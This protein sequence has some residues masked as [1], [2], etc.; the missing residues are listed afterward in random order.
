M[1]LRKCGVAALRRA[2]PAVGRTGVR[3]ISQRMRDEENLAD[4]R[5]RLVMLGDDGDDA[6]P[7]KNSDGKSL[8]VQQ[9]L[10]ARDS[11]PDASSIMIGSD[12]D[13]LLEKT[14]DLINMLVTRA[15]TKKL[16]LDDKWVS[17]LIMRL[18]TTVKR[19][20]IAVT[21]V[22]MTVQTVKT[23]MN[24]DVPFEVGTGTLN[25]LIIIMYQER[26]DVRSIY[27]A[28]ALFKKENIRPNH[29]TLAYMF[30]VSL[31]GHRMK[32]AENFFLACEKLLQKKDF[33]WGAKAE[34]IAALCIGIYD[35]ANGTFLVQLLRMIKDVC[36]AE[37]MAPGQLPDSPAER[38]SQH[39]YLSTY[40]AEQ[41]FWAAKARS[42]DIVELL[43]D[44]MSFLEGRQSLITYKLRIRQM[45][46][47]SFNAH[48]GL[49]FDVF[50]AIKQMMVG[51]YGTKIGSVDNRSLKSACITLLETSARARSPALLERSRL[52]MEKM[53]E[54]K[55][56]NDSNDKIDLYVMQIRLH[57]LSNDY[58]KV[59]ELYTA[60]K[61]QCTDSRIMIG[62]CSGPYAKD[63]LAIL[64]PIF[65]DFKDLAHRKR[66][67]IDDA[68]NKYLGVL[69]DCGELGEVIQTMDKMGDGKI[70]LKIIHQVLTACARDKDANSYGTFFKYSDGGQD[71][72]PLYFS[73]LKNN[74]TTKKNCEVAQGIFDRM[75][76]HQ[77]APTVQTY[78]LL[79][80]VYSAAKDYEEVSRLYSILKEDDKLSMDQ[81]SFFFLAKAWAESG[82]VDKVENVFNEL[83]ENAK[84]SSKDNADS[85]AKGK[86]TGKKPATVFTADLCAAGIRALANTGMKI[87]TVAYM[88]KFNPGEEEMDWMENQASQIH[89]TKQPRPV[90]VDMGFKFFSTLKELGIKP[91]PSVYNALLGLCTRAGDYRRAEEVYELL[92][93]DDPEQILSRSD[94]VTNLMKMHY[95]RDRMDDA[96]ELLTQTTQHDRVKIDTT[97]YHNC[98]ATCASKGSIANAKHVLTLMFEDANVKV[99]DTAVSLAVLAC[100]HYQPEADDEVDIV[101]K[102]KDLL[103][104]Y[105]ELHK[106]HRV[107]IPV[108]NSQQVFHQLLH[109][110]AVAKNA[111]EA[112]NV[113][114]EMV[115][116]N[117]TVDKLTM[118]YIARSLRHT[119]EIPGFLQQMDRDKSAP[120][121]NILYALLTCCQKNKDANAALELMTQ[122]PTLC[123]EKLNLLY[124]RI[125]ESAGLSDEERKHHN[126]RFQDVVGKSFEDIRQLADRRAREKMEESAVIERESALPTASDTH[127]SDLFDDDDD[128]GGDAQGL[129]FSL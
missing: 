1:L 109:V 112:R 56:V 2:V 43:N 96:M 23:F 83:L 50:D 71:A 104:E 118:S 27:D 54:L 4:S 80:A 128:A 126:Q 9:I 69:A 13:P 111:E 15:K 68:V 14:S 5:D 45:K 57:A 11:M 91:S 10:D 102:A 88:R 78:N 3:R 60:V 105:R 40:I 79:I 127:T 115:D 6:T 36:F 66:F 117:I 52:L 123:N 59:N 70:D 81:T 119:D 86:S 84:G 99:T 29:Q 16:A 31:R 107:R 32:N 12:I 95:T 25:A 17:K 98:I 90:E 75:G 55:I 18:Y 22:K 44:W 34:I 77:L 114:Q 28:Y 41:C 47:L 33:S 49:S 124:Y 72:M 24:A 85:D 76:D 51:P 65:L 21:P 53:I 64:K 87:E 74:R 120:D 110:C 129:S 100:A 89:Q 121:I 61:E 62:M 93:K 122:Y 19:R 116:M 82:S 92:K 26:V 113:V 20:E 30:N 73:H 106:L 48:Y 94:I 8:T 35:T 7:S 67:N 38:T 46:M 97:A 125:M 37:G 58:A 101:T 108:V 63:N 39:L 42:P 103:A